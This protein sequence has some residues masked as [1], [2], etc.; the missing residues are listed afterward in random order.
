MRSLFVLLSLCFCI[1][2]I[3]THN[4]YDKDFPLNGDWIPIQQEMAGKILPMMAMGGQKLTLRDTSYTLVAE[5]ID[6]GSVHYANGKM[7]IYGRDGVNAGK[8]FMAIYKLENEQLTVCYNLMGDAYP[9]SY[10]TKQHPMYFR[11][12]FKKA[13]K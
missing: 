9:L 10:E 11:S 3:V 6:K 1:S 13:P 4:L 8:H 12:V 7:D 5:S 2:C